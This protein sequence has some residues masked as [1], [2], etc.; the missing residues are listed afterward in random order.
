MRVTDQTK[1]KAV[2]ANLGKNAEELQE[3]MIGMSNGKKL[4]KPSDDPV[5]AAM[6]QDFHTSINRSQNLEKNIGSDKVW[7]NATEAATSQITE[8]MMKLKEMALQG[9]N[10]GIPKEQRAVL[11]TEIKMITDDLIKLANKREGKL[12]LFSGTKTF[13]EPLKLNSELKPA[14]I[15]FDGL[16]IKA[17]REVIP[18]D[19]DKPINQVVPGMMPGKLQLFV[20]PPPILD[21]EGNPLPPLEGEEAGPKPVEIDLMGDES[22]EEVVKKLNDAFIEAEGFMEDP[23]SPVGFKTRLFAQ[24]GVDGHLYLDP[25]PQHSFKFGED[26]TG[27]V[28]AMGFKFLGQTADQQLQPLQGA[29]DVAGDNAPKPTDEPIPFETYSPTFK[30]YSKESYLVRVSK[31]GTYGTARFVVSDD[32]GETWSRPEVLNKQN[33]IYNPE[34]KPSDKVRLIFDAPG[35]PYFL[36]GVEFQFEGNEFVEYHGNDVVK[37]VP[38][39]NG[40]KVAL[41]T[42]AP[43]MFMKRDEDPDSVNTFEVL[44]RLIQSLRDD[45]QE[46]VLE[47]I[48]D[49]DKAINQLLKARS[50]IGSRVLELESSEDRLKQN[51]DY[52][53]GE[54]SEI[55]DMD[56]AKGALD[57]NKAELKH[58]TAL[59]ASARLIQPTLVQFLK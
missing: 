34:G 23:E 24:I 11:S 50:E 30:G 45:E 17:D 57:L 43:E 35:K 53:A 51:M 21:A 4:N 14:E 13:T 39:D 40:I 26:T 8:T 9:A 19:Q 47:S 20:E 22:L 31:A 5:G 54:L 6:V 49:M 1:H 32:G 7:L 44:N 56:L 55:Q 18:L 58:Q 59:D 10:G 36:E 29:E 42:T 33:E 15:Q 28:K 12:F 16:R 52:K 37:Q 46:A 3:L 41:N 25:S 38:I 48:S 2:S 27:F